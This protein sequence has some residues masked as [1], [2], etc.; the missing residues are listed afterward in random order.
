MY[1]GFNKSAQLY[2]EATEYIPGGV[3]SPVR[4]FKSVGGTPVFITRGEGA[5]LTDVDGNTYIDYV[6]SWGPLILGHRHPEVIKALQ[7]CLEMGTS[8]GAPT[9]LE[10][11]L[12]KMII[13]AL[14]AMDMVRLVN[15]GTEATMSAIRLARGY[16]K[17]NKIIKFA[18][19]YHGHADFLLIKAGSGALTLGV[20]TSP[21]V[22]TGTAEHT[23]NA[24]FN[25]LETL[26]E[27]FRQVGED[28][29]AVIVE[30]VPGNMG[31]IP[32]VPGFLMGLRRLTEQYGAL[33]I[34]DEVMTGFRVAY[35]GAQVLY[36][37]EPDITCLGK[38]IGGGLPV[39][40]YG[41][42]KDIMSQVAP[43]GPVYQAGTL[44][45]NPLAVTAGIATLQLLRRPGVY[46]ELEQKS[47]RLES[48]LRQA[49]E[50]AGL[51]L[52][53]NRVGSMLCTFFTNE[54][55]TD[56]DSAFKSDTEQFAKY[57]AGM[58]RR[59]V[60]LA[61]SQFEAAFMSLAHTNE[62]I[63]QTIEAARMVFKELTH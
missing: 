38:I 55:V 3:N 48:G 25:D 62:Q 49:A 21:G 28:I 37:V 16:T 26:Q 5:M 51:N 44:S 29:A 4:A 18:G 24:P 58:L 40:A 53:F 1:N 7:G 32:P 47:A 20:P 6:G 17:R 59:G 36:N 14:P 57:F 43:A 22:P 30:P 63:D 46:D 39:G 23:I 61:P 54:P 33:L 35:G 42:K 11:E 27:I 56:F 60:Y 2:A 19:C 50:G 10:T 45:G 15:S 12:A 8:F 31:V 34:M 13:D 41:G 9:E 52:T